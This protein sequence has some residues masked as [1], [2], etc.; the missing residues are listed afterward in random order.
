MTAP[1]EPLVSVVTPVHNGEA[2][3][4]ECIES[5]L[6]QTYSN[7]EY[8]IVDNHST[9]RTGEIARNYA[10]QD[11]RVRV[12]ATDTFLPLLANWNHA[13]RQIS[14]T[15]KY[16]K[17][18]HADDW[19]F[20]ECLHQMVELAEKYPSAGIVGAYRLDEDR[21]N[22]DGLK[23]SCG[24]VPGR[25]IGRWHFLGGRFLFGSPTS[26]LIRA[27]LVWARHA[28]YNER[29][30]HADT[31]VC[32]DLLRG[33]DFG[34]VH[35]VLTFTRRHNETVTSINRRL[36]TYLPS[37]LYVLHKYGR[38]YL[39]ESEYQEALRAKLRI[40]YRFLGVSLL[41]LRKKDFWTQ[42]QEFWSYHGKALKDLG[43]PLNRVRLVG[44]AAV[45]L[46]NGLLDKIRI[47]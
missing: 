26:V 13:L 27:D 33:T 38:D 34:F 4:A 41:R 7:W 32:F 1:S 25:D 18:V 46:Y 45:V 6:R 47:P 40:Y 8:V 15:S 24:L 31:E 35:Q 42:R 11:S 2:Y 17:V 36:N 3:L 14:P 28:F 22:L 43:H 16:C 30:L 5:V 12:Y 20:P 10:Q 39:S 37:E 19:L 23:Y 29:N 44:A 21:V 9:D